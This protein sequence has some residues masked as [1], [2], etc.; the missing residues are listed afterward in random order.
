MFFGER[1]CVRRWHRW[2]Y[3]LDT[4]FLVTAVDVQVYAFVGDG[5]ALGF[6]G[7]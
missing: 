1:E 6:V 2:K 4:N 7:S 3:L 5:V